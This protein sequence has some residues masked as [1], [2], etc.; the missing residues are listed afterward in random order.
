MEIAPSGAVI[1]VSKQ[2]DGSSSDKEIVNGSEFLKMELWSDGVSVM[3]DRSFTA[4]DELAR[5]GISLNIPAFLG[6]RY[7][8][9]KKK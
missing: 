8:L 5:L 7:Y 9:N 2:Y 4:H 6:G 3:T 1:F